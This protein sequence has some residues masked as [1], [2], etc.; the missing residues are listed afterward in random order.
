MSE[1][2]EL[3][4]G[5][6]ASS[7]TRSD[8]SHTPRSAD[9]RSSAKQFALAMLENALIR[10][11]LGLIFFVSIA[12]T[13]VIWGATRL[14]IGHQEARTAMATREPLGPVGQ[15][16][17]G[18]DPAVFPGSLVL[19]KL[20]A[21]LEDDIA[22]ADAIRWPEAILAIALG[23]VLALRTE[24]IA[25]KSAAIWVGLAWFSS[26]AVMHR[27][28]EFGIDVT[29]S[30]G[31]LLA[32]DR[33]IAKQGRLD[34]L[35]GFF[36]AVAFLS[37]G[38]P[39][40]ILVTAA[41]I[42]LCRNS[43]GLTLSYLAV[44]IAAIG[45]W[46]AWALKE[47][48]AEAWAAA[49][50]LPVTSRSGKN[51]PVTALF[52]CM[53]AILFVPALLGR[54]ARDGWSKSSNDY[55]NG[56]WT[57]AGLCFFAGTVLPQFGKSALLP[58]VAGCAV[59][60]GHVWA[61]ALA[62]RSETEAGFERLWLK[63]ATG[64]FVLATFLAIPLLAYVSVTIPYYRGIAT[65]AI[66]IVIAAAI[67]YASGLASRDMRRVAIGF[68][69]ACLVAKIAHTSI[70]VPEWNYRRGQG[71]WGRAV[72][73]WVPEGWPIYTLHGWP[74]DFA[75]ATGHNFRQI[76][77]PR[78]LP[79]AAKAPDE[80]PSFILLHPADFEH[81]PKTAPPITKMFEFHDHSGQRVSKVLART[82][83]EK[84]AWQKL[85]YR[86]PVTR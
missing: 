20:W 18:L 12:V 85:I 24:M 44:V 40:V 86:N 50:A 36:V 56:W 69:M 31:L 6:A 75:F 43:S 62:R 52:L 39:P 53:P 17:G 49:I 4:F 77:H 70:V 57:V 73:Q 60:M 80:R 14:D 81:W 8:A 63:L 58:I 32:L 51:F 47:I 15:S 7:T 78:F 25:G 27:S 45:G 65:V 59:G 29:G 54:K 16:F 76:T 66:V 33:A 71:P 11:V 72:G 9:L 74:A 48:S 22:G 64:A 42:A 28:G 38:L 84:P 79:D 55:V 21:T 1:M 13:F 35:T 26:I 37:A 68:M 23:I 5:S 67:V 83:P 82:G 41:S 19:P 46:S 61:T 3:A 34:W 2:T 10:H 30:F